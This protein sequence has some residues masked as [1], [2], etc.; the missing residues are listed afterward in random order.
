MVTETEWKT[1]AKFFLGLRLKSNTSFFVVMFVLFTIMLWSFRNHRKRK[2]ELL[3]EEKQDQIMFAAGSFFFLLV[4]VPFVE[5]FGSRAYTSL[6]HL[7]SDDDEVESSLERSAKLLRNALFSMT[8]SEIDLLISAIICLIVLL[9]SVMCWPRPC[10]T[11][12]EKLANLPGGGGG[13]YFVTTAT[14]G[15]AGTAASQ[16]PSRQEEGEMR[17]E[18]EEGSKGP[19]I[20]THESRFSSRASKEGS[21]RAKHADDVQDHA[22]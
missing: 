16:R 12:E 17:G 20:R 18:E 14:A 21:R 22:S 6:G 1:P 9:V 3:A 11:C 2:M 13:G 10:D 15:G 7:P 5:S 8:V 19:V 4:L